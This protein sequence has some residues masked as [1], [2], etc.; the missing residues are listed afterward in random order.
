VSKRS[1]QEIGETPE[2]K[3]WIPVEAHTGDDVPENDE[4]RDEVCSVT[5]AFKIE[6]IHFEKLPEDTFLLKGMGLTSDMPVYEDFSQT[7]TLLSAE[8]ISNEVFDQVLSKKEAKLTPLPMSV[9]KEDTKTGNLPHLT[10]DTTKNASVFPHVIASSN[11][12]FKIFVAVLIFVSVAG[13]IISLNGEKTTI[14]AF[15]ISQFK[16]EVFK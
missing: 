16:P 7:T 1:L 3:C 11:N 14:E 13:G 10:Q 5:Y 9:P 12:Y 8:K 15:K 2:A 6:K 4:T